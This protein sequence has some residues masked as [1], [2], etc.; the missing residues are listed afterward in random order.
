MVKIEIRT[1]NIA[2]DEELADALRKI[3]DRLEEGDIGGR[4]TL[5]D[6]RCEWAINPATPLIGG[7]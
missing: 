6:E 4:F 3:L 7:A 1:E 5:E 2:G